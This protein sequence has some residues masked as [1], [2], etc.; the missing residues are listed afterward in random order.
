LGQQCQ[1]AEQWIDTTRRLRLHALSGIGRERY[2]IASLD[3]RNCV[4]SDV[5]DPAL[6]LVCAVVASLLKGRI[7]I[8]CQPPGPH[9]VDV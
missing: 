9:Y 2:A 8:S 6:E 3:V 1:E 7:V 4:R 5:T